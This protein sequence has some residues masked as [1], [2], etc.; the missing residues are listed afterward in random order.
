MKLAFIRKTKDNSQEKT[1]QSIIMVETIQRKLSDSPKAR[2]TALIIVAFTMMMGY[3]LTDVMS[4]LEA[5]LETPKAQ[6]GLGW[7]SS[8]YGFFAGSYGLINVFLLMLFFGGIIL[9]K[10]GIRFTGVMACSLMVAGV[11]IKYFG[12]ST[13]FGDSVFSISA[14]NFSLPMSAA[15]A[16]LGYA[17]F[18]VG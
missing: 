7:T 3:F 13:D 4:P 8:N 18:G 15:V 11:A 2:W 9:D 10:M 14:F 16:S 1:K 6:G 5:L 17:I 12:V